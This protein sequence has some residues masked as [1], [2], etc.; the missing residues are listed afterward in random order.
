MHFT[1][2]K[3]LVVSKTVRGMA[4]PAQLTMVLQRSVPLVESISNLT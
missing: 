4:K 3:L 1:I 2:V